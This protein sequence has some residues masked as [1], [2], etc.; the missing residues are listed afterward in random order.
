MAGTCPS[1]PY[2]PA[3]SGAEVEGIG[4]AWPPCPCAACG[5]PGGCGGVEGDW[6]ASATFHAPFTHTHPPLPWIQCPGTHT[7]LLVGGRSQ[8]PATH[9]HCPFS[10]FQW[11]DIQTWAGE[12]GG[13]TICS[14]TAA[15]GLSAADAVAGAERPSA[16]AATHAPPERTV[17]IL[18]FM[19]FEILRCRLPLF[20]GPGAPRRC[21]GGP[22][23]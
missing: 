3:T 8:C 20:I 12:G 6:G 4:T 17:L 1:G 2:C 21:S 9:F 19:A 11:P 5:P 22:P 10:E 7:A 18:A 15:V 14:S 16:S 23:N 13:P